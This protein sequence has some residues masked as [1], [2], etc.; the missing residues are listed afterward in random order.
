[1]KLIIAKYS[2][3]VGIK[4]YSYIVD[5]T[6]KNTQNNVFVKNGNVSETFL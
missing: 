1:M 3:N 5:G 2:K 4:H 6:F